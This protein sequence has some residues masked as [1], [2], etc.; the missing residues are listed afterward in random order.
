M[1]HDL[2]TLKK[3]FITN[4]ISD[5]FKIFPCDLNKKPLIDGSSLVSFSSIYINNLIK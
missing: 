1:S 5:G 4:F 3:E 2:V